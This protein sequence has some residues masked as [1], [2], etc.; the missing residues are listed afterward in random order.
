GH[1]DD[2]AAG[3]FE[4]VDLGDGRLDVVGVGRRHRLHPDRVVAADHLV[5][6]LDLTRLVPLKSVPIRHPDPHSNWENGGLG[7]EIL[8]NMLQP[9][10]PSA[11]QMVK[12]ALSS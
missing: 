7:A 2:L 10:L 6:D 9:R 1:A 8:T 4:A 11:P 12:L 3:F 5:A